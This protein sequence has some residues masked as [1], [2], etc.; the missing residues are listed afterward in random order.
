MKA[1]VFHGV[2]DLRF[3][4]DW[5]NPR[6]L[7][8]GEVRVAVAW[9]GIC[10]TDIEDIRQGAIIPIDKPHPESG[11]MAPL[12]IGHEYSGVVDEVAP[13]VTHVKPGDRVAMECVAYCGHCLWCQRGEYASCQYQISIGQH[14]DGGMAEYLNIPAYNCI[15]IPDSLALD[16]A[17][18]AEPLAV[19]VRA[20]RKGRVQPGEI[21]TVVGAGA[22]GLF[23]IAMAR[24][25]G[26]S[27]VI[28]I[29]HGGHRAEVAARMGATHILNSKIEGWHEQFLDLTDGLGSEVVFDCGGNIP[30][31]RLAVDL[32]RKHGRTVVT[33]VV[34]ADVPLSA[35]DIMY[36]EKEI[37]GSVAHQHDR[38]FTW[39]VQYLAD[40]RVNPEPMI[41]HRVYIDDAIKDGFDKAVVDRNQI[42]ILVTPDRKYLQ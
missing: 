33:S 6:P 38:E 2:N 26:A 3:E 25:A 10:G 29:T 40:G 28:A 5:P 17:S 22:I 12:V 41:T 42:K 20:A 35:M 7:R 13:D 8:P 11:R 39:A 31:I 36:H 19:M 4:K 23:G 14:D 30:A 32:A 21:V 9:C 27:K 18:L 1:I 34:D 37:I 16:I 24:V 15:K